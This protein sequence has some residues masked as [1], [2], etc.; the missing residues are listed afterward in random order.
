MKELSDLL[1]QGSDEF[2]MKMGRPMS[3]AEMREMWG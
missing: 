1:K 2:K 3:Y